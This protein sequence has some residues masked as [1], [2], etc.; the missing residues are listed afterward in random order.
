MTQSATLTFGCV[1]NMH[2]SKEF[3]SQ[4][5]PVEWNRIL[6]AHANG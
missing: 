4:N 2:K 5:F 1:K 6:V 3:G